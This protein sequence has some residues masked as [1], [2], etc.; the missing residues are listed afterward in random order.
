MDRPGPIYETDSV[1]I[2]TRGEFFGLSGNARPARQSGRATSK[3]KRYCEDRAGAIAAGTSTWDRRGAASS[4]TTLQVRTSL[5][6]AT[7]SVGC[8]RDKRVAMGRH[9]SLILQMT[10]VVATR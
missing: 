2:D 5:L 1:V 7:G 6:R 8:E 3:R 9:G 10:N 4:V